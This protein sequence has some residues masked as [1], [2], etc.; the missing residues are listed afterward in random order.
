MDSDEAATAG[1]AFEAWLLA[2]EATPLA[3]TVRESLWLYPAVELTHILGFVL[4]VGSAV[5]FDLRL[6][7]FSRG[8][9][10]SALA[11]HVLPWARVGL[12]LA[13][14]TGLLMFMADASLTAANPAFRIKLLL[15]AAGVTNAW[16]FHHWT[17]RTVPAWDRNASTPAAAR[18]AAVLSLVSWGAALA[19]GRLIAYV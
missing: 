8:I 7:G 4:L 9:A 17:F 1:S 18:V 16:A 13:I 19:C 6:L 12:G 2:L 15:V 11:A 14:P 10:V 5:A 3:T